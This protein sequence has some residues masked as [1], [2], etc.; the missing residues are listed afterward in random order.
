M[1]NYFSWSAERTSNKWGLVSGTNP[2]CIFTCVGNDRTITNINDVCM[3]ASRAKSPDSGKDITAAVYIPGDFKKSLNYCLKLRRDSI[4]TKKYNYKLLSRNC[5]TEVVRALSLGKFK[6]ANTQKA[7][8]KFI[9]KGPKKI[10][11]TNSFGML[12][13]MQSSFGGI[14]IYYNKE[15]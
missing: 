3:Y 1:W 7:F 15:R 2:V 14:S 8:N 10:S 13:W 5:T 12:T 11:P 9:A 4:S 6:N